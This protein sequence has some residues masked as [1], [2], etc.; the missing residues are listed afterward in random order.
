MKN[1]DNDSLRIKITLEVLGDAGN[2]VAGALKP[3]LAMGGKILKCT[4]RQR[5]CTLKSP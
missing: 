3:T 5:C 1:G 2:E 4:K